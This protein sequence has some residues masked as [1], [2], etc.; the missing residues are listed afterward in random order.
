MREWK[1][2]KRRNLLGPDAKSQR[3]Q[4]TKQAEQYVDEFEQLI[5]KVF[6]KQS[7][8]RETN[9]D[10]EHFFKRKHDRHVR[11]THKDVKERFQSD[12]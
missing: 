11:R 2:A 3:I 9:Y 1:P 5:A 12:Q 10:K 4:D 7:D 8:F 6:Y